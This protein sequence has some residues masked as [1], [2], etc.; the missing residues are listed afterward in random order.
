[1]AKMPVNYERGRVVKLG[2]RRPYNHGF[3]EIEGSKGSATTFHI[4]TGRQVIVRSDGLHLGSFP[5]GVPLMPRVGDVLH[6]VTAPYPGRP[7]QRR[8][9]L[10]WRATQHESVQPF[11]VADAARMLGQLQLLVTHYQRF[12]FR[13]Q[14]PLFQSF[15]SWQIDKQRSSIARGVFT[16]EAHEDNDGNGVLWLYP[17]GKRA[18]RVDFV[19][20]EAQ[21][22]KNARCSVEHVEGI[23][24]EVDARRYVIN[25][26]V[27]RPVNEFYERFF[28]RHPDTFCC[29][30]W[31]LASKAGLGTAAQMVRVISVIRRNV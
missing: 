12:S 1:M 3:I 17:W 2:F 13:N 6:C 8:C 24:V 4:N 29:G 19:G 16:R 27:L 23:S 25:P 30:E 10:W 7:G 22:L 18:A 20:A 11:V 15:H 31:M 9:V 14:E 28:K 5:S 26:H 21:T